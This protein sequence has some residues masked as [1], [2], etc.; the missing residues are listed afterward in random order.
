[1]KWTD[2]QGDSRQRYCNLCRKSVHAMEQYSKEEWDRLWRESNGKVCGYSSPEMPEEHSS[3][4][5][6]LVGAL[7]TAI[8]PLMAQA[9]RVRIRVLDSTGAVIPTAEASVLAPDNRPLRTVKAD[10][11]G[12]VLLRD[13]PVGNCRFRVSAPGFASKTLTIAVS[14]IEEVQVDTKLDV[15]LMGDV[16]IIEPRAIKKSRR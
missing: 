2:L 7:L 12:E 15:G 14:E 4:R 10:E 13:L 3:R 11:S 16:V 6:V 1:M 9:G 8:A 5:A